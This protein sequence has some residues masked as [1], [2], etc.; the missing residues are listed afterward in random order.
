MSER[1]FIDCDDDGHWYVVPVAMRPAWEV[2]LDED[3]ND[4]PEW[5][6][7]VGGAVNYVTFSDP[8]V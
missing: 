5:A 8:E 2:W 1:F 6:R 7:E 3:P 4:V